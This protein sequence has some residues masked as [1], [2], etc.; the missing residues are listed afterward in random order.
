MT[1]AAILSQVKK[2][3]A[4]WY[5]HILSVFEFYCLTS[6]QSVRGAFSIR[7]HQFGKM[8][9]DAEFAGKYISVEEIGKIFVLVNF[10]SDKV[11]VNL[12]L[13]SKYF[14]W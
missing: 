5:K 8:M 1:L 2:V 4:P 9:Q 13:L 14:P 7:P 3:I 11:R 12:L 6:S 10:E